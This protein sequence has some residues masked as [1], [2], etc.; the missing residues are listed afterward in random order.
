MKTKS[1]GIALIIIGIV[2]TIYTG[3][4]YVTTEK[5]V[6]IGPIQIN[7]EQNHPVQWAPIVGVIVIV[8]GGFLVVKGSSNKN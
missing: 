7:K 4:N 5:V 1:I 3:F 2:M 8:I 6:D